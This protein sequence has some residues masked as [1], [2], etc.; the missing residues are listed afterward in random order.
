MQKLKILTSVPTHLSSDNSM[1]LCYLQCLIGSS[2]LSSI[3]G[4]F[5]VHTGA[6]IEF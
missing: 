4:I 2:I 1:N 5:L 3:F 6:N